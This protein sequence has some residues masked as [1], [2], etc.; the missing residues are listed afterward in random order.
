MTLYHGKTSRIKVGCGTLYLTLS[1]NDEEKLAQVRLGKG[2]TCANSQC[3][4]IGRVIA[5]ALQHG[6]PLDELSKEL[7]GI[8]CSVPCPE[9]SSCADG[10]ARILKKENE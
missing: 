9:S 1:T 4:A 3:E 8:T 6:A 10:I 5:I 7:S 2:G